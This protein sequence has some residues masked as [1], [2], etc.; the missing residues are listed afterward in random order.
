MLTEG[1]LKK[2]CSSSYILSMGGMLM[3]FF[4]KIAVH[5]SVLLLAILVLAYGMKKYGKGTSYETHAQWLIRTF[6]IGGGVYLPI[7]TL[8][9]AGWLYFNI[10]LSPMR[11]ALEAGEAT[12]SSDLTKLFLEMYGDK[13][14]HTTTVAA[15]PF[16]AWWL[17]R[18]WRGYRLL[19]KGQP[20][21]DVMRWVF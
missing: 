17:W 1:H 5:G 21:P 6:W 19:K 2:G 15:I 8:I 3:Q 18:C 11:E 4:P 20:V 10:D 9:A 13:I 14:L 16:A 7:L 12:D